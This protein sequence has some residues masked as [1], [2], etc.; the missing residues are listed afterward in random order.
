MAT[1]NFDPIQEGAT[2]FDPVA[3]GATPA[4]AGND[5]VSGV[6]RSLGLGILPDTGAAVMNVPN[7]IQHG[8]PGMMGNKG[9]L[10]AYKQNYRQNPLVDQNLLDKAENRDVGGVAGGVGQDAAGAASLMVPETNVFKGAGLASKAGNLAI[11]GGAAGGLAGAAQ[12][13]ATPQSVAGSA[14]TGA[15]LNPLVTAVGAGLSKLPNL[16]ARSVIRPVTGSTPGWADREEEAVKTLLKETSGLTP[17]QIDTSIKSKLG[18]TTNKI[19]DQLEKNKTPITLNGTA[20]NPGLQDTLFKVYQESV[21]GYSFTDPETGRA[22][23]QVNNILDRYAEN[24]PSGGRVINNPADLFRAKQALGDLMGKATGAFTKAQKGQPLNNVDAVHLA[25]YDTL[26]DYIDQ[27]NPGTSKLTEMEHRLYQVGQGAYKA[28]HK[29]SENSILG[30]IPGVS[31]LLNAVGG[32][33]RPATMLGARTMNGAV[34]K[35]KNLGEL[36]LQAGV[37]IPGLFNTPNNQ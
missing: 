2:K 14:A 9:E 37:R 22:A 21:P 19:L 36:L 17:G 29:T 3:N 1:N 15:V 28:S 24:T 7:L 32:V 34:D 13:N 33:A 20:E 4:H 35:T 6:L 10:N 30:N 25:A 27:I 5:G 8:V 18:D 23:M 26:K 31:T 12:P 16:L 11:R